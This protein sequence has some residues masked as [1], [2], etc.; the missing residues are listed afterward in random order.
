MD[1]DPLSIFESGAILT[2]LGDKYGRFLAPSGQARWKAKEW[3]FWQ[4][5]GLGPM[6]G[7]VGFFAFYAN[8][9]VPL[10]IDRYVT[11][12]ARLF[13]VLE[14]R[15][16]KTPYLAGEAFSIADM[17]C[18]PWM[19]DAVTQARAV[20]GMHLEDQ[21]AIARWMSTLTDRPGVQR[22]MAIE[23]PASG[24]LSTKAREEVKA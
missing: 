23:P 9:K 1:G 14:G 13:K 10:A 4:T 17:A 20:V 8:E 2:Y 15:L 12:V 11:E 22:G 5:S 18:Y 19:V 24:G 21:P 7:Q 3:L 6:M 16:A